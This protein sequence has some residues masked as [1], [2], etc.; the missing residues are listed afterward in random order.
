MRCLTVTPR[1]AALRAQGK[2][3]T[4]Q[5]GPAHCSLMANVMSSASFGLQQVSVR[6][7]GGWRP[8]RKGMVN[9]APLMAP[10][11]PA[12]CP[13]ACYG[14]PACL[15][16]LITGL[17]SVGSFTPP[18]PPALE[19]EEFW[20]LCLREG[21]RYGTEVSCLIRAGQ[22]LPVDFAAGLPP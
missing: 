22:A 12:T 11:P 3:L 6:R 19:G 9:Q 13:K 2:D 21:V 4:L 20:V 14:L 17:C 1:H 10:S 7:G 15:S 8:T 5:I 18:C 16:S